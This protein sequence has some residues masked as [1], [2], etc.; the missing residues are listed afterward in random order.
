MRRRR[1]S[2][3]RMPSAMRPSDPGLTDDERNEAGASDLAVTRPEGSTQGRSNRSRRVPPASMRYHCAP[4]RQRHT[5]RRRDGPHPRGSSRPM[6]SFRGRPSGKHARTW[7]DRDR[8][9]MLLNIGFGVTIVAALLLLVVAFAA[10]WYDDNLAP[11][12]SVERPD[13]HQGRVQ[14]PAGDQQLPDR[15]RAAPDPDA[16]HRGPD[17]RR[18]R[19]GAPRR[20]S[21]SATS[22]PRRSR[23]SS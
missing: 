16:A 15:L 1:D 2:T 12:G 14:P 4:R 19:A 20:R 8:R 6:T 7:D 18:R 5:T 11:A 13:D 9:S 10:S 21:S 3:S 22:R 17:P 23:S